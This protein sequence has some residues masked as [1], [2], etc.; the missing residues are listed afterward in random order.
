[1]AK[2]LAS[3]T[4]WTEEVAFASVGTPKQKSY[5]DFYVRLWRSGRVVEDELKL[6]SSRSITVVRKKQVLVVWAS[7]PNNWLKMRALY[8][9]SSFS[10]S[11]TC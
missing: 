7:D 6:V 8:D 10:V 9:Y 1:M 4:K 2:N 5:V 3:G 11:Y